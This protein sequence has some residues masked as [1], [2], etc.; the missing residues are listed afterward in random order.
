MD[1]Q[2]IEHPILSVVIPVFN[3]AEILRELYKR[4]IRALDDNG[5]NYEIIFVNDNSTDDSWAILK[6]LSGTNA[7]ISC[8]DLRKNVGCDSAIM[9]GLSIVQG[10][11]IIIMDDDLQH[12]PE[13]IPTLVEHLSL[14]HDL[15]YANFIS[16]EQHKMK[17]AGSWINGKMAELVVGKPKSIYL[18]PF[19]AVRREIVD[20]IVKYS[21][22]YPY[23]DGLIFQV[24]ERISQVPIDHHKRFLG[25][26]NYGVLKS[27]KIWLN[28]ATGFS[29]TPLRIASLAGII[30]A[31]ITA[32]FGCWLIIW[33]LFFGISLEGWVSTIVIVLFLGSVQLLALGMLGE[34]LGRMYLSL[35]GKRQYVIKQ[36]I[37][38]SE[39]GSESSPK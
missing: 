24:T 13:D 9:A 27:F 15:V 29:V 32:G 25:Q 12:A 33:K 37:G 11:I 1:D 19:K 8:I 30:V 22:P 39:V 4:L 16:K 7:I 34:Y 35:G 6:Q 38:G 2:L 17:N 14:G 3:C 21:G 31:T 23:V 36:I 28:L 18:S 10:D 5:N 26:G 20:E